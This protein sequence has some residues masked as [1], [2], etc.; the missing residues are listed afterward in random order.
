[1]WPFKSTNRY[2]DSFVD[3]MY[4]AIVSTWSDDS[5]HRLFEHDDDA[6]R[7]FLFSSFIQG[8]IFYGPSE[9]DP[10]TGK[11][12]E[13]SIHAV[14][15]LTCKFLGSDDEVLVGDYI[16]DS[17]ERWEFPKTLKAY[18]GIESDSSTCL[19][20]R[21]PLCQ[22][23]VA[24][25]NMRLNKQMSEIVSDPKSY[26]GCLYDF[27]DPFN[28]RLNFAAVCLCNVVYYESVA[29]SSLSASELSSLFMK[30]VG[31]F[32]SHS[33]DLMEAVVSTIKKYS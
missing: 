17:G 15:G 27:H 12:S 29:D 16:V 8:L 31:I 25:Y 26:S 21:I 9:R 20:V 1:M 18:F 6:A 10:V 13:R 22:L 33:R 5:I 19:D 32:R 4:R 30:R 23:I 24:V 28:P 2:P 14:G 11:S 3:D 7:R